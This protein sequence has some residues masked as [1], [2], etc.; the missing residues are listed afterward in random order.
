[1][2]N[3]KLSDGLLPVGGLENTRVAETHDLPSASANI[4]PEASS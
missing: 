4:V 3:T 1:M 2:S